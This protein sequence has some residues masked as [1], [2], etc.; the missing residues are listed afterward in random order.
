[1][2]RKEANAPTERIIRILDDVESL[3]AYCAEME[4]KIIELVPD[5]IHLFPPRPSL[6]AVI[7]ERARQS[8]ML[9]NTRSRRYYARKVRQ[10]GQDHDVEAISFK[11]I[12][13]A[14]K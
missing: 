13:E 8:L 9:Q 11:D 6:E 3:E 5:K 4:A 10:L 7:Q 12:E 2:P 1:M 14:L